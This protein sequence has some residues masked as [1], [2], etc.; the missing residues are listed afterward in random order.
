MLKDIPYNL[1]KKDERAYEIMLLRDQHDNTFKDIAKEYEIS[2]ARVIEIYRRTK[3]HQIRLYINH[4]SIMLDH[5]NTSQIGKVFNDANECYWDRTYAAAYL[6]KKYADI[7]NEY[8][9]GE[10]GMPMHFI[11]NMPPYKSK[12]SRKAINRVIEMREKEKASFKKIGNAL[13]I[14]QA[15]AK[16]TYDWF[17]HVKVLAII[18]DLQKKADSYEEER[19][20][21]DYYFRKYN[22]PKRR[23][24]EIIKNQAFD[25]RNT[26]D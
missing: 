7:L 1:L 19:A 26:T 9:A 21:R 16:R 23:Y 14:T 12:L 5:E 11:K 20:I 15:K 8:R 25:T 4:I 17:Y 24:D 13:R 10:P 18:E 22:S 6:E 3:V 2:I